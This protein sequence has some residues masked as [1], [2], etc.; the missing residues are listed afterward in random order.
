MGQLGTTLPTRH[1]NVNV[2]AEISPKRLWRDCLE[3]RMDGSRFDEWV[4]M[5][6][7]SS[8][9]GVVRLVT[10]GG[11]AALF[12][13]LGLEEA[14]A[15]C[16]KPGKKCKKKNSKKKK[17]CGGAKCKGKKC[18]CQDGTFA[19]GKNCC[20]PGQ[21]CSNASICANGQIPTGSICDPAEPGACTSGV[22]GCGPGGCTCRVETCA[23]P[24]EPC[25]TNY[26]CC[27]SLCY[28]LEGSIC[29]PLP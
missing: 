26:D 16:V 7:T 17:C 28:L 6:G 12:A 2:H 23:G 25:L 22:C 8:R 4:R 15:K 19:C 18:K 14:A 11:V 3:V 24:G 13:R 5:W 1:S 21:V 29:G 10:G 20:I 27:E 9:R